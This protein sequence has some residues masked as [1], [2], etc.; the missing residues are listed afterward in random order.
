MS[1]SE[2]EEGAFWRFID[3]R[4]AR[5]KRKYYQHGLACFTLFTGFAHYLNPEVEA[6][7]IV[8]VTLLCIYDPTVG[9][10]A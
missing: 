10:G 4:I 3:G 6:W 1:D 7:G 5:I 2:K 8:I 9:G